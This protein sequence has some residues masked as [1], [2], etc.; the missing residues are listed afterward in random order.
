MRNSIKRLGKV[1]DYGINLL[2]IIKG[3]GQ[4]VSSDKELRF[5]GVTRAETVLV[6]DK[7]V[8][9]VYKWPISWLKMMCSKILLHIEVSDTGR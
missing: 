8:V 4:V 6:V 5:A 9:A 7:Y 1:E 3:L 2:F